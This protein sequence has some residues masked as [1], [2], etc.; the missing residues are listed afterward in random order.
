MGDLVIKLE[1]GDE[2]SIM[3]TRFATI[4]FILVDRALNRRGVLNRLRGIRSKSIAPCIGEMKVHNLH[5]EMLTEKNAA[6]IGGRI[7]KVVKVENPLVKG[8]LS[9]NY[10]RIRVGIKMKEP[11]IEGFWVFRREKGRV[12]VEIRYA[13]LPN[14]RFKCGCLGHIE[15]NCDREAIVETSSSYGGHMRAGGNRFGNS[16]NEIGRA[17]EKN[18]G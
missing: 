1:V 17:V 3:Q 2:Q 6:K 13:K 5:I 8:G 14:L 15:K 11:L 16:E 18:R 7:G 10:L 4:G 9:K 12:W